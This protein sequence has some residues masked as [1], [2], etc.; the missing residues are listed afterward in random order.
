M[1]NVVFCPY[2]LVTR[3][4]VS[5]TRPKHPLNTPPLWQYHRQAT[6]AA[7]TLGNTLKL[8]SRWGRRWML[9]PRQE[10]KA[11]RLTHRTVAGS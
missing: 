11:Q 7:F 4:L 6:T 2:S 1:F 9:T 8:L 5:S 10:V 3:L